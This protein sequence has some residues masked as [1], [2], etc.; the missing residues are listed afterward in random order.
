MI[1]DVQRFEAAA[2]IAMGQFDMPVATSAHEAA[3]PRRFAAIAA[4]LAVA[5]VVAI[6]LW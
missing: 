2:R 1:A 5:A 3:L 6:F 4:S